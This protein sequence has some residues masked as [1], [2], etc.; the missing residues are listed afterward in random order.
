MDSKSGEA[1]MELPAKRSMQRAAKLAV[2]SSVAVLAVLSLPN[3]D[4]GMVASRTEKEPASGA[5]SYSA[6]FLNRQGV[7]VA[8]IG[9]ERGAFSAE[10]WTA[11]WSQRH[12][13][14]A[15]R[16][17]VNASGL[18]ANREF[19]EDS[20]ENLEQKIFTAAKVGA[21]LDAI[22]ALTQ[23]NEPDKAMEALAHV[24]IKEKNAEVRMAALDGLDEIDAV[25]LEILAHVAVY[26]SDPEVRLRALNLIGDGK[27]SGRRVFALLT[28][29]AKADPNR[30][31]RQ[32]A[33]D[34]L[35]EM[36][37]HN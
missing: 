28:R 3:N 23:T 29:L 30:A 35:G 17:E 15:E 20:V 21:K 36:R 11:F 37:R 33:S 9:A 24:L 10:R 12:S 7:N 5:S 22:E 25:P 6:R 13:S 2:L 14:G 4:R 1:M 31:V 26:D 18:G 16:L 34:L 8:G 32:S 27:E 19:D